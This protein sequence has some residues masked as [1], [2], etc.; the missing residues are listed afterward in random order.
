[1]VAELVPTV[2]YHKCTCALRGF[3]IP[4]FIDVLQTT[5][6]GFLSIGNVTKKG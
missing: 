5:C 6:S 4:A 2:G 3:A 1:M